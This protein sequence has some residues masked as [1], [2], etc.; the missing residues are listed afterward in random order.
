[1]EHSPTSA[2]GTGW[3]RTPW[4][5]AGGVEDTQESGLRRLG[6][7][8][9]RHGFSES[10]L[11]REQSDR[12]LSDQ[13]IGSVAELLVLVHTKQNRARLQPGVSR[14]L[15]TRGRVIGYTAYRSEHA[16]APHREDA[17]EAL[18]E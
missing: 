2:T 7:C 3:E 15:A 10:T 12:S 17:V 18:Q 11:L 1:M 9:L 16:Q 4:H 14:A 6:G 5:A 13:D 8:S